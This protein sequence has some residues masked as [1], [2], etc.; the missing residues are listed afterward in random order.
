MNK[1]FTVYP[2]YDFENGEWWCREIK[3]R[4]KSLKEFRRKLPPR[5][6]VNDYYMHEYWDRE[7][8]ENP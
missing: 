8:R 1:I 2:I 5:T 7:R 6:K 4:G 3:V